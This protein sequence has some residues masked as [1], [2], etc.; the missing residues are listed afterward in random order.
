[1]TFTRYIGPTQTK[2]KNPSSGYCGT[3]WQ[4]NIGEQLDQDKKVMGFVVRFGVPKTYPSYGEYSLGGGFLGGKASWK[5][6]DSPASHK[7][8]VTIGKKVGTPTNFKF[9]TVISQDPIFGSNKTVEKYYPIFEPGEYVVRI[10][11]LSTGKCA[12]GSDDWLNYSAGF[13]VK[14]V[15]GYEEPKP[16]PNPELPIT[17]PSE[18][19]NSEAEKETQEKLIKAGLMV[20]A[21]VVFFALS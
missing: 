8:G 19:V 16:E 7:L 20:G 13:D 5:Q 2:T 12:P 15:S 4:Y 10:E 17:P 3:K 1:M 18:P 6:A 14:E 9:E 11:N 21:F